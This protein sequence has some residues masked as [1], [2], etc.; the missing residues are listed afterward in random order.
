MTKKLEKLPP[1]SQIR[2]KANYHF[3]DAWVGETGFLRLNV[4]KDGN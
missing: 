2:V 4:G 3:I 1:H